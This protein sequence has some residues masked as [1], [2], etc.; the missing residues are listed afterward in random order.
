MPSWAE[1]YEISQTLKTPHAQ[2][3]YVDRSSKSAKCGNCENFIPAEPVNRCMTVETPISPQGWC[4][5]YK[6]K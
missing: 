2:V 3:N 4:S 6:P 1:M 5:R